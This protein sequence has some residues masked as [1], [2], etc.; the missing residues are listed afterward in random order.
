[1]TAHGRNS[2]VLFFI[3]QIWNPTLFNCTIL[4]LPTGQRRGEPTPQY[5][6]RGGEAVRASLDV[7]S[8]LVSFR[9]FYVPAI[10][11][12]GLCFPS[13]EG[14][15]GCVKRVNVIAEIAYMN[16]QRWTNSPF[17]ILHFPLKNQIASYL[18]MTHFL[19]DIAATADRGLS[20]INHGR[21]NLGYTIQEWWFLTFFNSTILPFI[22]CTKRCTIDRRLF[23]SK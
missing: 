11:S 19:G 20:T 10:I 13:W 9:F 7:Q 8:I 12:H 5:Q 23:S 16:R 17:S 6:Y 4:P 2:S 3:S 14:M 18:V 1:M 21:I 15:K 22:N